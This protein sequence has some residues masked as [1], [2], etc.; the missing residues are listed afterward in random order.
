ML[1][2]SGAKISPLGTSQPGNKILK[3]PGN[4]LDDAAADEAR[5]MRDERQSRRI[6]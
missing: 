6:L 4:G 5:D 1:I 2:R 3:L